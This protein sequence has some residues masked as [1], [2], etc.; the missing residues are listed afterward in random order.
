MNN[1][2]F[3]IVVVVALVLIIGTLV[4]M[5]IQ[6]MEREAEMAANKRMGNFK[7]QDIVQYPNIE[8]IV[9]PP[10]PSSF[11][12]A[13][14]RVLFLKGRM[15]DNDAYTLFYDKDGK[16]VGNEKTLHHMYNLSW[17][18]TP[19][20]VDREVNNGRGFA[21][22]KISYGSTECTMV[23][24]KLASAGRAKLTENLKNQLD[25]YKKANNTTNGM[26]VIAY[27]NKNQRKMVKEV[28][29]ELNLQEGPNTILI[30]AIKDKVSASKVK[31]A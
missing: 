18:G 2:T 1:K 17:Y 19:F 7:R 27:F 29:A 22:F 11:D 25:V 6:N 9:V 3:K 15:E 28:L 13:Y 21:D 12:A 30:D 20:Q 24:F 16:W 8:N 26:F 23:E 14:E 4:V 5:Q 31:T 10:V